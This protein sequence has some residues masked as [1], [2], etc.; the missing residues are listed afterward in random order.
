MVNIWKVFDIE[1]VE[2]SLS[3]DLLI[4]LIE[5][6]SKSLTLLNQFIVHRVD[7]ILS[8][9]S[10]LILDKT[11]SS[12]LIWFIQTYFAGYYLPKFFKV[13][14]KMAV[15]P[16]LWDTL[17]KNTR[18]RLN[19]NFSTWLSLEIRKN[20]NFS[21]LEIQ[22]SD[23]FIEFLSFLFILELNKGIVEISKYRPILLFNKYNYDYF[24]RTRLHSP[25][26]LVRY[27]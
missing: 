3:S 24:L 7:S 22:E 10:Q 4:F 25:K 18:I 23:I 16:S 9:F 13:I 27:W 17:D 19:E 20:S 14:I 11:I 12:W 1:I 2:L 15:I 6:N 26:F 5:L 8:L 21:I